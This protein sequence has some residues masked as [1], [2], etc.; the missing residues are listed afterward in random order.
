MGRSH[1]GFQNDFTFGARWLWNDVESTE[2]LSL[3]TQDLNNDGKTLRVSFDRRIN[4]QLTFE[5][6]VRLPYRYNRDPNNVA[7]KKDGAIIAALIFNF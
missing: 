2:F 7:L 5:V 3:L 1:S 4:N 6:N